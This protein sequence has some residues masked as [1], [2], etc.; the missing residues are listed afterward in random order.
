MLELLRVFRNVSSSEQH[1]DKN[2][3]DKHERRD[4]VVVGEILFRSINHVEKWKTL[5]KRRCQ[6]RYR[7]NR[8]TYNREEICVCT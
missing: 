5:L 8:E 4:K 7:P 6:S 1:F 3:N 2:C